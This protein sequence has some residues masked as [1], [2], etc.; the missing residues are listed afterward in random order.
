MVDSRR[1]KTAGRPWSLLRAAAL[2]CFLHSV[3]PAPADDARHIL[4]SAE[5]CRECHREHVDQ[6]KNSPLA[7][8]SRARNLPLER[9]WKA[10][11]E[12]AGKKLDGCP[13]CHEPLAKF[14]A[15]DQGAWARTERVTCTF[16]HAI[17]ADHGGDAFAPGSGAKTASVAVSRKEAGLPVG[18]KGSDLCL[19]CHQNIRPEY[20]EF[21]ARFPTEKITCAG[22]HMP[23]R[24]G[25]DPMH[26]HSFPGGF[27]EAMLRK[28][29]RFDMQAARSD[30]GIEVRI[31][32]ANNVKA[33]YI[34]TG[35]E[36]AYIVL[37]VQARDK[38]GA[39]VWQNWKSDPV[40]ECPTAIFSR[41]YSDE[42][43]HAPIPSWSKN[44]K[45]LL[46]Q[47]L[48]TGDTRL[49]TYT[50]PV[51]GVARIEAELRYSSFHPCASKALSIEDS[52]YT[53]SRVMAAE[54]VALPE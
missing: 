48:K 31:S 36:L 21:Q 52:R 24:E 45:L 26:S 16:C 5:S 41:I 44:K 43:G 9:L 10:R 40:R 6:W 17:G 39:V 50:I 1:Q 49:L 37:Q 14:V 29:V 19:R 23:L 7:H 32:A 28:A 13:K 20:T 18:E 11:E 22:C 4:A 38:N 3:A 15:A 42:N 47:R 51:Q 53:A 34:P 35:S 8:F 12:V 30:G 2:C 54:Q 33:H 27:S 25:K 46:D